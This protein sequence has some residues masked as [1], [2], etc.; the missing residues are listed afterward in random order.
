MNERWILLGRE[1][2]WPTGPIPHP[3]STHSPV[4]LIRLKDKQCRDVWVHRLH[5]LLA[6]NQY[7]QE[8]EVHWTSSDPQKQNCLMY[9]NEKLY[10]KPHWKQYAQLLKCLIVIAIEPVFIVACIWCI[11]LFSNVIF[12]TRR[13]I[14]IVYLFFYT[15]YAPLKSLLNTHQDCI[16]FKNINIV[17]YDYNLT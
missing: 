2:F 11:F 16:Y 6:L 1:V 13:K 3:F 9:Y 15:I 7:L 8:P 10:Y 4:I 17:K 12:T 5:A 14:S